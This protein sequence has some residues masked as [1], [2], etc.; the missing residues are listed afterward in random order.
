MIS[1]EANTRREATGERPLR[2]VILDD[3]EFVGDAL[4]MML[5]LECKHA[6]ILRFTAPEPA[7]QELVR[8]APDLFTTDWNHPGI[9][10]PEMLRLLVARQAKYPVFV[11]SAHS[12][13]I[14]KNGLLREFIEAGLNITLLAKPFRAER[15]RSALAANFG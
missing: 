1:Q 13:W 15:L 2:I 5:Q 8:L 11:V 10:C 14:E 12:E 6:E 3:E 7:M 4:S 9:P